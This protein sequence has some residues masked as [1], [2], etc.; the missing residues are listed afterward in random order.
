[1]REG[2][3]VDLRTAVTHAVKQNTRIRREHVRV[4]QNGHYVEITLEVVPF[5]VPPS[6]ERYYL[7]LFEPT[8]RPLTDAE[9]KSERK[10]RMHSQNGQTERV[11]L[12][13]ELASTR[14]SLQAIIEEQEATNEELRSANEEIMSSNEELQSTNEELE[15]AKEELQSTNEELTT[16]NEELENRN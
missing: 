8:A 6:R 9:A 16:L 2:L 5:Q 13:E 3:L 1:A 4:K 7:V 10:L 15:T 11:H 14:E 12:R